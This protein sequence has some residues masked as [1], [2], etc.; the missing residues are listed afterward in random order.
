MQ[1]EQVANRT[2]I[3]REISLLLLVFRWKTYPRP[4]G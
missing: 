1:I 2:T 4:R 3:M